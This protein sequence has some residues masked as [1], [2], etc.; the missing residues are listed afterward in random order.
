MY[1]AEIEKVYYGIIGIRKLLSA[2]QEPPIQLVIDAD[3]IPRIIEL[4][5]QTEE[6]G[7][8]A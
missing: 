8:K 3:L 6:E 1:S 2:A 7:L 5:K 4:A